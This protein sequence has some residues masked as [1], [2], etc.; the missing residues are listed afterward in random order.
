MS[1]ILTRLVISASRITS[2]IIWG[3][4]I[5][6]MF[7][8]RFQDNAKHGLLVVILKSVLKGLPPI[9]QGR[10]ANLFEDHEIIVVDF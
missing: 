8:G 7:S 5:S 1:R 10:I 2:K 9:H 6:M 4:R 3:V